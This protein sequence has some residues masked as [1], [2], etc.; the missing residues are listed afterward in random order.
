ML[1]VLRNPLENE[2]RNE[3]ANRL[4]RLMETYLPVN[5]TTGGGMLCNYGLVHLEGDDSYWHGS[6]FALSLADMTGSTIIDQTI[7]GFKGWDIGYAILE[8][9]QWF[10]LTVE[11]LDNLVHNPGYY[12]QAGHPEAKHTLEYQ[13]TER[14]HWTFVRL[15]SFFVLEKSLK[16]LLAIQDDGA[17]PKHGHHL[18]RLYDELNRDV[19]ALLLNT[20]HNIQFLRYPNPCPTADQVRDYLVSA[21]N[22]YMNWRY[23]ESSEPKELVLTAPFDIRLGLSGILSAVAMTS[24]IIRTRTK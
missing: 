11:A 6:T 7:P 8:M 10:E 24:N 16:T 14:A 22:T 13:H 1:Q 18:D 19:Q 4:V 9:R 17:V 21:S 2:M 15:N 12:F 23:R 3:N 5:E 20:L